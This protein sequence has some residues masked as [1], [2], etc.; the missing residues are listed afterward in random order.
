MIDQQFRRPRQP[1][2]APGADHELAVGPAV[3]D[4]HHRDWQR[5]R[6][7][8]RG[9]F[10][11][12]GDSDVGR[13]HL[14]DRIEVAQPGAKVQ[15]HAE[16]RRVPCD[17]KLQRGCVGETDEIAGGSFLE[18]DL[19]AA[20]KQSAP[21]GDQHQAIL[22]ECEALDVFGQ[23]MLGCKAEIRSTSGNCG[24]DIRAFTL[25]DIDVDVGMLVQENRQ[26]L[27][28][29]L[30][31]PRG[32]G[33]KMHAG[34]QTTGKSRKVAAH[35]IDV[36]NHQ[37]SVIEQTFAGRRKLDTAPAAF[38]QLNAERLLQPFDPGT[39]GCERKMGAIG[40]PR[41]MLRLSATAMKSCRSTRS[42]RTD[43]SNSFR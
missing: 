6:T 31:K 10:R 35:R 28:Q 39:G 24:R 42:K 2:E 25:F 30:R 12:Y 34:A 17:V 22:A 18:L 27:R 40:A 13:H 29:V 14:A 11:N 16:P 26:R 3:S 33:E 7:T 8:L 5:A 37:S 21:R 4:P 20:G 9:G 23:R 15:P 43:A 36:M 1:R 19:A 32:V 41:V 38:E